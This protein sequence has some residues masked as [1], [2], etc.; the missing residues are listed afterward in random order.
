M[1]AQAP[2]AVADVHVADSLD[3]V[4]VK[5]RDRAIGGTVFTELRH[6]LGPAVP[7]RR[8]SAGIRIP[9]RYAWLLLDARIVSLKW[10]TEAERFVA[11][12]RRAAQSHGDH[13]TLIQRL[14]A[15]GADF[16]RQ[17][18]ADSSGL[19]VLDRHQF[20]NV[21]AMTHPRCFGLCVFD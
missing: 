16:A 5:P 8:S 17:L 12:R 19:D 7:I 20:V 3:S 15:A 4:L 6:R 2:H 11:N 9:A 13:F 18:I 21:A 14:K 10:T 1:S